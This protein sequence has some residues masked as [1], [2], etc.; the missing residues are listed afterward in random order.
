MASTIDCIF[1][2]YGDEFFG[3]KAMNRITDEQV[4]EA[5]CAA[6]RELGSLTEKCGKQK[7][8]TCKELFCNYICEYFM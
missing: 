5:R 7:D 3:E 4:E 1:R 8:G 2:K 6:F